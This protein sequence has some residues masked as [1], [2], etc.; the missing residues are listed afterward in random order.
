MTNITLQTN[1]AIEEICNKRHYR[2]CRSKT[3]TEASN[4]IVKYLDHLFI[5]YTQ[6]SRLPFGCIDWGIVQKIQNLRDAYFVDLQLD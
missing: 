5:K 1:T 4:A 2:L 6:H 3:E